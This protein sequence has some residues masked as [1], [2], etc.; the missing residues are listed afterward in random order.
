MTVFGGATPE[1]EQAIAWQAA[2]QTFDRFNAADRLL[3]SVPMWNGSIPYI[4]KQFIDVISQ[5]GMM[6]GI[7]PHTGYTHL[8]AAQNKRVAVIYTSA[9][10]GPQLGPQFGTDFQVPY[11]TDCSP[12]QA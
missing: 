9:V 7:D 11:F 12:G 5:P 8:L 10:W 1:G 2:R 3:F 4:L 6:F